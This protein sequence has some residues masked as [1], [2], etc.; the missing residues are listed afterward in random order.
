[1]FDFLLNGEALDPIFRREREFGNKQCKRCDGFDGFDGSQEKR[2][3]EVVGAIGQLRSMDAFHFCKYLR[4][5]EA[6]DGSKSLI[7]TNSILCN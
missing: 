1:M 3:K 5:G 7:L 2:K 6:P 4:R